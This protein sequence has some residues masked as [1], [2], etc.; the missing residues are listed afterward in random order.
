VTLLKQQSHI[1]AVIHVD[2]S[3]SKP[4]LLRRTTNRKPF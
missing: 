4:D 2:Y 3:S 1:S